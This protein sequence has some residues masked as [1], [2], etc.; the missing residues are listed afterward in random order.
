M[1]IALDITIDIALVIIID[2]AMG[3][4]F[5]RHNLSHNS[6]CTRR[7]RTFCDCFMLAA[8]GQQTDATGLKAMESQMDAVN[9]TLHRWRVSSQPQEGTG[10]SGASGGGGGGHWTFGCGINDLPARMILFS[11][12]SNRNT[13]TRLKRRETV[14]VLLPLQASLF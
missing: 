7:L 3:I 9:M 6:S 14:P 8:P 13:Y 12:R 2:T 5:N 11:T 10:D 4:A 1:H